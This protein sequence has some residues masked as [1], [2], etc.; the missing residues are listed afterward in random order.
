MVVEEKK[1]EFVVDK[2]DDP[3]IEEVKEEVTEI[4][5]DAVPESNTILWFS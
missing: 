1:E 3:K 2:E 5:K 4:R